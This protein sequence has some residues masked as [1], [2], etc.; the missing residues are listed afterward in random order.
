MNNLTA[1]ESAA[2]RAVL[3]ETDRETAGLSENIDQLRVTKRETTGAGFNT[4]IDTTSQPKRV[5]N[6]KLIN[7][8][9]YAE[10]EGIPHGAGFIIHLDQGRINCLEC[11]CYGNT[12]P[13]DFS[14]SFSIRRAHLD[15]TSNRVTSV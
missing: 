15:Q 2:L 14:G 11:I 1:L 7:N 8:D 6:R 13:E 10:I 5:L 9:V 12:V 3:S 4:W